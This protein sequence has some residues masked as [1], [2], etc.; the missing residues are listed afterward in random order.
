MQA[1]HSLADGLLSGLPQ[2]R[3]GEPY[4]ER[5]WC[6]TALGFV[7][8]NPVIASYRASIDAKRSVRG[9]L[10]SGTS[11]LVQE[12]FTD[13]IPSLDRDAISAYSFSSSIG[14]S[15]LHRQHQSCCIA[16]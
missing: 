9:T 14:I 16:T 6:I 15:L 3:Q 7:S 12:S 13:R 8:L 5:R 4:S 2:R 10:L 11:V 1:P